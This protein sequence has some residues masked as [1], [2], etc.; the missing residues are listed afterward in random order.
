MVTKYYNH[1]VTTYNVHGIYSDIIITRCSSPFSSHI[2]VSYK[3][4]NQSKSLEYIKDKGEK[5]YH[6]WID[7]GEYGKLPFGEILADEITDEK[8]IN[9]LSVG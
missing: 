1:N 7:R 5:Y 2:W 8:I 6:L 4:D 3:K 9:D